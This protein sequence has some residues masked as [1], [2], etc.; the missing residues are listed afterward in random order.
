M[1]NEYLEHFAAYGVLITEG[2]EFQNIYSNSFMGRHRRCRHI[3]PP[4]HSP[5]E[6]VSYSKISCKYK[7]I[8]YPYHDKRENGQESFHVLRRIL[9]EFWKP[10]YTGLDIPDG[11]GSNSNMASWTEHPHRRKLRVSKYYRF[12]ISGRNN[13]RHK[14]ISHIIW[15]QARGRIMPDICAPGRVVM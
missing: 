4:L 13:R 9:Y 11:A 15:R 3:Q 2:T 14:P 7:Q 12:G 6:H 5:T 1:I 10:E 8:F